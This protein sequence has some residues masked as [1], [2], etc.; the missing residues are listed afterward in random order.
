MPA[1]QGLGSYRGRASAA[2][3]RA[4]H[5]TVGGGQVEI[6]FSWTRNVW[7]FTGRVGRPDGGC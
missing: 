4:S 2:P 5:A 6:S 3:I 7:G 1:T